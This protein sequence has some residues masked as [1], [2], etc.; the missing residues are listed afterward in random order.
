MIFVVDVVRY[1]GGEFDLVWQGVSEGSQTMLHQVVTRA[2]WWWSELKTVEKNMNKKYKK[3][4][5]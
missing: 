1:L 3:I 5:K 4:N 2:W